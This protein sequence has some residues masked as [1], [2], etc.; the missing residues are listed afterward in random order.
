[1]PDLARV[2]IVS[3]V[4]LVPKNKRQKRRKRRK[5]RQRS[6]EHHLFVRRCG[7]LGRDNT[8]ARPRSRPYRLSCPSRPKITRDPRDE[9]DDSEVA[10]TANISNTANIPEHPE[11]PRTSR[12]FRTGGTPCSE[13][14]VVRLFVRS[15]ARP[16]GV[17]IPIPHS[18]ITIS[19]YSIIMLSSHLCHTI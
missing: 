9:R 18:D 19:I 5:R 6:R 4:P 3:L 7:A 12:T 1:M 8:D 13:C 11:Q 17:L 14:S 16:F 15:L 10:D 2:P